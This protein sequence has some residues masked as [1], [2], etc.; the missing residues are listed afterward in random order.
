LRDTIG[1]YN[2]EQLLVERFLIANKARE[3]V[4]KGIPPGV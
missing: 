3:L 2:L 4:V 1:Q